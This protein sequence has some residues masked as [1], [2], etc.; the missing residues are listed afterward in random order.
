MLKDDRVAHYFATTDMKKQ[1]SRQKQFITL[2]TGGPNIYE[3]TDMKS[4]HCK[5]SIGHMEYDATWENL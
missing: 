1:R 4:A 2:V 5:L 3:G